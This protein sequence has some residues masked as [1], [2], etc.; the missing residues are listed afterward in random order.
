MF[1]FRR[2][3][4]SASKSTPWTPVA[5]PRLVMAAPPFFVMF[6]LISNITS[7]HRPLGSPFAASRNKCPLSPRS[8]LFCFSKQT[9]KEKT[10]ESA[11]M[12]VGLKLKFLL[13]ALPWALQP[14]FLFFLGH[15]NPP[16][17]NKHT[18]ISS[19]RLTNPAVL[20]RFA[21]RIALNSCTCCHR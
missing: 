6:Q 2:A 14:W 1:S 7:V 18:R 9:Q 15:E 4:F 17:Y 11:E 8:V 21:A 19:A 16:K 20:S 10:S 5:Q 12:S 13:G 3:R